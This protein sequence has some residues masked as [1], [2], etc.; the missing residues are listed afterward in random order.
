MSPIVIAIVVMVFVV[1]GA[2]GFLVFAS[3]SDDTEKDD[4]VEE[5]VSI[6]STNAAACNKFGYYS[7]TSPAS[8]TTC[9]AL[10]YT[11]AGK[12]DETSCKTFIDTAKAGMNPKPEGDYTEIWC[13]TK[14]KTLA[15]KSSFCSS[16]D[17]KYTAFIDAM[18]TLFNTKRLIRAVQGTS[19]Q[20]F[21]DPNSTTAIPSPITLTVDAIESGTWKA[22]NEKKTKDEL[23]AILAT[24][25]GFLDLGWQLTGYVMEQMSTVLGFVTNN[26][27]V[28]WSSNKWKITGTVSGNDVHKYTV[29]PA[30]W[31]TISPGTKTTNYVYSYLNLSTTNKTA[32]LNELKKPGIGG[33]AT[34]CL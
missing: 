3:S 13:K 9:S 11:S 12:V 27:V 5:E 14:Y 15:T 34:Y 33:Y 31:T 29:I 16:A 23:F 32:L 25:P 19:I 7:N 1:L 30:L 28:A 10:G 6:T 24:I 4:E 21:Y 17:T 18:A 22:T 8:E 2:V 26:D 20:Y